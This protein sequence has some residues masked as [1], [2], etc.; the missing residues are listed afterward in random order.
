MFLLLA[1]KLALVQLNILKNKGEML[2]K[3]KR[4]IKE[5]ASEGAKIVSLPV[6]PSTDT[7]KPD[8][9]ETVRPWPNDQ[10]LFVKH[11]RF[12]LQAMLVCFQAL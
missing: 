7:Y 5:A 1:I 8:F 11:L 10:T 6:S 4:L 9:H 3:T 2:L 12:S